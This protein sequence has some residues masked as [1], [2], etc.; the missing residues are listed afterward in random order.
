HSL[1][2]L[3]INSDVRMKGIKVGSV[4]SLQISKKNI[5]LVKVNIRVDEDTPVKVDTRATIKRNLLTGL[6]TVDLDKSS[7]ES[8]LLTEVKPDE[9]YPV[10]PEGRSELDE[11]AASV[12]DLIHDASESIKRL[13]ALLSD[14]NVQL[15]HDIVANVDRVTSAFAKRDKDI[16]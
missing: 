7:Q 11:V 12:P 13:N 4:A 1:D 2:G 3:Q 5:A 9:E 14:E 16:E 10:I 15:V 8:A 6:A